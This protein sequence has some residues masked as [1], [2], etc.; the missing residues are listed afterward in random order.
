MSVVA[1]WNAVGVVSRRVKSTKGRWGDRNA[2]RQRVLIEALIALVEES[3]P[4]VDIS[5]QDIADR[6]G[7]SRS[8]IYRHFSNRKDLDTKAREHVIAN[9]LDSIMPTLDP[10]ETVRETVTVAVDTYVSLAAEHPR[11]YQWVEL[12]AAEDV[13]GANAV[14]TARDAIAQQI[15]AL[16]VPAAAVF[17]ESDPGIEIGVFAVVSMI[18]GAVTR[19]LRDRP[20]GWDAPAVARTLIGTLLIL[21]DGHARLRGITLDVDVPIGELL[22]STGD[23]LP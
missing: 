4:G 12:A 16:I 10:A 9:Y 13:G 23:Q 21:L 1:G 8:V 22:A 7:I 14:M 18:D 6:A 15:S 2:G 19:W 11:L 3:E 17:G 5:F 20:E